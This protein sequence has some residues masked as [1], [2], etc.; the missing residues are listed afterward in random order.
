MTDSYQPN[1][2]PATE[3]AINILFAIVIIAVGLVSFTT[4]ELLL[5]GKRT[6]GPNGISMQGAPAWCMSIAMVCACIVL[7][8]VVVDHYDRRNNERYYRRIASVSKTIG[9]CA[10]AASLTIHLFR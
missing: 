10:F 4:G 3:R 5:P 9:W 7:L 1:H 6:S 8:S 2:I